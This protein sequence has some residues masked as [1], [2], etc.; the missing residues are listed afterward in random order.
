[1]RHGLGVNVVLRVRP[2]S[3]P[4]LG[5]LVLASHVLFSQKVEG[6]SCAGAGSR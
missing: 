3:H 4:F 2:R 6:T 1:M 5:L